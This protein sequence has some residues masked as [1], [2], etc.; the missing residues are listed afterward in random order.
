MM[1]GSVGASS[2]ETD[3]PAALS[4]RDRADALRYED[5]FSDFIAAF[6]RSV[7][8]MAFKSGWHIDAICEHLEAVADWQINRLLINMPPR[9]MK[10]LGA[11]AFFPA[12]IW[13]QNPNPEDDPKY[14]FAIR[15]NSW[16]GPGVKFMHLSYEAQLA[17]RDGVKC[18][19]VITSPWYQRLWGDRFRMQPDQNQKTR[20]DNLSGGHRLSTSEGGVITGEG[21]DIIIFDDPHNVRAVGGASNVAREKT[22]RF[23]DES[24]PSRLNDQDHGAF[25][26]IMQRV[27]ERDL[28]GHILQNELGWTHL[29]LPAVYEKNHPFPIRTSVV[30]KSFGMVWSDPR[31]EGE[32]LWPEKFPLAALQRMT[33]DPSMSSHMA[34]GQLQQRPTAREGGLIKRIWFDNPVKLVPDVNRLEFV[35]AWDFAATEGATNDPDWTVGVL[36]GRDTETR[37]IY[38]FDVIRARLSPA[39]RETKMFATAVLDRASY[40]DRLKIRIPQ[41]PGGSGKFEAHHNVSLLQG[42]S[43]TVE[44]ED[45]GSGI[46]RTAKE[47]RADPFAAQCEHGMVKLIEAKWNDTFVEELCAF[48]NGAHDDQVDAASAAFRALIR[49]RSVYAV[50]A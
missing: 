50:G 23:W 25:V 14:S 2:I 20:F 26:V 10:S 12:W 19:R 16:R 38:V 35:R 31:E 9:H 21:A 8:P 18:R 27:H 29:C 40:G 13:A 3:G 36:M 37:I 46:D 39:D 32:A 41:D 15:R 49:R 34:A 24:M 47:R 48:P 1:P 43:V 17:T 5:S 6:W 30:R 28:T 7:E 42:Y 4:L 45:S 33:N 11:N 22:L 44:R